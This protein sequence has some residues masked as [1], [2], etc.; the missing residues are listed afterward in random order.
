MTTQLKDI[1]LFVKNNQT[2][3]E[4]QGSKNIGFTLLTQPRVSNVDPKDIDEKLAKLKR[5]CEARSID[6]ANTQARKVLAEREQAEL[7]IEGRAN[8]FTVDTETKIQQ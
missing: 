8:Q 6:I 2:L 5:E 4:P 7:L 3:Q 1:K